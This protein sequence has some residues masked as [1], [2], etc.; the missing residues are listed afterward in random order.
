MH[1]SLDNELHY[2]RF[3]LHENTTPFE[4]NSSKLSHPPPANPMGSGSAPVT[5][6]LESNQEHHLL[7]LLSGTP[8][9][10]QTSKLPG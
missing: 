2:Y 3:Y 5:S 1:V 4:N 6:K 10:E 9:H 8:T 7:V